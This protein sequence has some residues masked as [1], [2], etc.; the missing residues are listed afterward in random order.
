LVKLCSNDSLHMQSQWQF[1]LHSYASNRSNAR[2]SRSV[3]SIIVY[4]LVPYTT[5]LS[6]IILRSFPILWPCS[7][8]FHCKSSFYTL[9]NTTYFRSLTVA[10]LIHCP[11]VIFRACMSVLPF[12]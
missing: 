2:R 10:L 5:Y 1:T 9:F 4:T 12:A 6:L 8:P 11:V 7:L 3:L